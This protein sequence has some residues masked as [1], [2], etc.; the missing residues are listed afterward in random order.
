MNR[1]PVQ[2]LI[3][4]RMGPGRV[5]A[6]KLRDLKR[7]EVKPARE[8]VPQHWVPLGGPNPWGDGPFY[9][10]SRGWQY[11]YVPEAP[12]NLHALTPEDLARLT[13]TAV[14]PFCP[15]FAE[16]TTGAAF[17]ALL[18]N[19]VVTPNDDGTFTHTFEAD[20]DKPGV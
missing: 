11:T 14:I 1:K 3:K 12:F 8:P 7:K 16:S 18:G 17:A 20:D 9:A 4:K 13:G 5:T 19:D 6:P 2:R 10:D 15:P